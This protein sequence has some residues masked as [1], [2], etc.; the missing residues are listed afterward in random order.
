MLCLLRSPSASRKWRSG[1]L[2]PF[3]DRHRDHSKNALSA[4][5]FF[6][7][8]Y[9]LFSAISGEKLFS[10]IQEPNI[11]TENQRPPPPPPTTKDNPTRVG[12]RIL[13]DC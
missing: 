4:K 2:Q 10:Y 12:D 7:L 8:Y 13:T 6:L 9:G 5:D 3:G 11:L 1:A